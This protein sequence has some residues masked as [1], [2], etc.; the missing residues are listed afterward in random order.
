L[1]YQRVL[2]DRFQS[3]GLFETAVSLLREAE[4]RNPANSQDARK[5]GQW[6]FERWTFTHD[7]AD[8]KES[9]Q[10]YRRAWEGYPTNAILMA[11]Y[12]IALDAAGEATTAVE[13]GE[14]ALEQDRLNHSMAHVDRYLPDA[15]REQLTKIGGD[16]IDR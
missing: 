4:K 13:M 5:L 1:A 10:N 6:W 16:L 14:K 15:L 9:I 7:L 8:A 2:S 3:N 12:A 11:E